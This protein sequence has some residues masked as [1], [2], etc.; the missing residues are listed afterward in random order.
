MQKIFVCLSALWMVSSVLAQ[1]SPTGAPGCASQNAKQCVGLALD[2]MGGR[3]RLEQVKSLRLQII[4]HTLLVEQSY[5]QAPFVASYERGQVTMD[6]ANQ[7]V[8]KEMKS[9]WPESDHNQSDSDSIV[10]VGPEGGVTRSQDR[11]SP[12]SLSAL[13]TARQMLALGPARVL[14]TASDAP[15]LH[16]GAPET[17]RS[18]SHAVVVFTWGK[19]PVRVLLNPFNHLPD[20]VETTQ[21]FHDF[22]YF[23][24][25]VQQRIYFDNFKLSQGVAFPTNLVEERNGVVWSS[26]QALNVEFNVSVDPKAFA[27]DPKVA[28]QSAA[29]PGWNRP[30]RAQKATTL[31]PGVDLFPGAWNSTIVKQSDG[32][33]ILEAPISEAYT[34]GV[35]EEARKRYPGMAVKAVLSTSDSWP[36]TGGVRFAV[37]ENLPI[38]ILDLNRPLLDRM[39]GAP[40]TLYPDALEKSKH[41]KNPNWK[42][43]AAKQELGSGENRVELYPLR[44]A[45]TE[46]QYMVY[47]PESRLLYASDT[48]ALNNNGSLYDPELMHEVAQAVKRANLNVDTV[49]AM[50]QGPMPWSQVLALIEKSQHT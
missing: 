6:L 46:R 16:F 38:Y 7:G 9:T 10:V 28:K 44:G 37:A 36:H 21:E 2:A 31:A 34:R 22:W 20:A 35:I 8:L 49:F 5:R 14:I 23:W 43:V 39:S 1:K 47:F 19:I 27:M 18:T 30:F 12:C 13:D 15:D 40:H 11:D 33:V 26:T 48:L 17:L 3:E 32:I 45:S 24:G 50:H 4:G 41:S 25:D 42:I 29:S